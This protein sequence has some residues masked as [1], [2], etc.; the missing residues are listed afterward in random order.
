MER[1]KELS[2]MGLDKVEGNDKKD[3]TEG[4]PPGG[5]LPKESMRRRRT[6]K[7]SGPA[8]AALGDTWFILWSVASAPGVSDAL[9]WNM[10]EKAILRLRARYL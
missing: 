5:G 4:G 9:R 7:L 10:L 8:K 2:R 1:A 6:A 3:S